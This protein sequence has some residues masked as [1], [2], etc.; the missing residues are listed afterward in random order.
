M[1]F[2][3][4][5]NQEWK[6]CLDDQIW[7]NCP[8]TSHPSF[9]MTEKDER[10]GSLFAFGMNIPSLFYSLWSD[11]RSSQKNFHAHAMRL[12]QKHF[13]IKAMLCSLT[14]RHFQKWLNTNVCVFVLFCFLGPDLSTAGSSS[15]RTFRALTCPTYCSKDVDPVCGSDGVIYKNECDMRK[16]TCNRGEN[17]L[18]ALKT[19]FMHT[20]WLVPLWFPN[21]EHHVK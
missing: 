6:Y 15:F 3:R 12:T 13:E 2:A 16:R 8:L 11:V 1:E 14:T 19:D 20:Y 4:T 21:D 5:F 17:S 10:K 7:T 9:G 18:A